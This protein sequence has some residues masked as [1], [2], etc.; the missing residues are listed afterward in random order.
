MR[1]AK[2]LING[3]DI[4]GTIVV[5]AEQ[6]SGRGRMK[7]IW[8]SPPG[9]LYFTI[10]LRAN[11]EVTS[12]AL[13]GLMIACVIHETIKSEFGLQPHLKWPNDILVNEKKLCG[14]LSELIVSQ[15]ESGGQSDDAPIFVIIGTGINA[16]N[17]VDEFPQEYQNLVTTIRNECGFKISLEDLLVAIIC[18]LDWWLE[19]DP[20]LSKVFHVYNNI[21]GTIGTEVSVELPKST[22]QGCAKGIDEYGNLIIEDRVGSIHKVD[23]GDVVYLRSE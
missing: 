12:Y 1:Y 7:R 11:K 4:D 19:T 13:Y 9:G 21:C 8:Y 14:V 22:I 5:A 17:L 3:G 2:Q 10:I 15:N 23:Y 16:N 18:R 6:S 20:S